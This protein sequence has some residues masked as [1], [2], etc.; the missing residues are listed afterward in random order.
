MRRFD[1]SAYRRS[2]GR[3]PR[4]YGMWIF[5]NLRTGELV[6]STP[7]TYTQARAA[8]PAGLWRVMP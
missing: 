2:H 6:E 1:T 8:L 7:A 5:L 3:E 4:G